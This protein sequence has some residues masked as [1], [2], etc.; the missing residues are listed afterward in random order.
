[1]SRL[2]GY[3]VYAIKY[4]NL[5]VTP[6][7]YRELSRATKKSLKKMADNFATFLVSS[8]RLYNLGNPKTKQQ[9]KTCS[10]RCYFKSHLRQAVVL[11]AVVVLVAVVVAP[12]PVR[13]VGVDPR[14][15]ELHPRSVEPSARRAAAEHRATHPHASCK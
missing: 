12:G 6:S 15:V 14:V 13:E 10:F 9:K 2:S 5:L 8:V 4:E 3:Y 7:R 11:Q 1:M